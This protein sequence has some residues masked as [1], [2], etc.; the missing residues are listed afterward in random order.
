MNRA[1]WV[2]A[3]RWY[4]EKNPYASYAQLVGYY[5]EIFPNLSDQFGEYSK[6]IDQS[7]VKQA[8]QKMAL[9]QG[10]SYPTQKQWMSLLQNTA[11]RQP[12]L[13]EALKEG[14]KQ[15]ILEVGDAITT[16]FKWGTGIVIVA[17]VIF[18]AWKLGLFK[19]AKK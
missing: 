15:G 18:A 14:T 8:V 19:Y 13:G 7:Y 11:L 12:S 9:V 16:G 3:L 2:N 6:L 4:V 5:D 1:Y 17:G 10:M